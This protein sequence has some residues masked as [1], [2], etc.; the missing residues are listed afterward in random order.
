MKIN[1]RIIQAKKAYFAW[2]R[3]SDWDLNY[4]YKNPSDNK[5]FKESSIREK[6]ISES[7]ERY[8]IITHS[9]FLFTCGYVFYDE[10]GDAIFH[11]YTPHYDICVPVLAIEN[12][13][14]P[15][16]ILKEFPPLYN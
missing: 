9:N 12:D 5:L 4:V 1:A 11:Y 8:R 15:S 16:K 10:I 2:K 6:F 3:S 14:K 7:G 13:V